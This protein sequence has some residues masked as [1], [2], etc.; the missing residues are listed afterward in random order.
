MMSESS[1]RHLILHDDLTTG[2]ATLR[3]QAIQCPSPPTVS[4][5]P[6]EVPQFVFRVH[7]SS[8]QTRYAFSTGFSSKNQTTILNST[9]GLLRFGLA[10]L[11]QQTNVSSPF[12]SV[13]DD[14]SHAEN[15]ARHWA[16][17]YAEDTFVVT[18]DT[19]HF[20]RGPVFRAVDLLE[21]TYGDRKAEDKLERDWLHYG[22]YLVLYRI[23]AQAIRDETPV[24]RG[25]SQKWR[26]VGV[27]G[28]G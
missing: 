27:I 20:A 22:E 18:V 16:Q 21:N 26:A 1:I 10:H 4:L 19:Q 24:A 12:I 11:N 14:L 6:L 8:A 15:V 17:K 2:L 13:Y 3:T 25:E 5:A 23:P 7:R 9:S 28:G